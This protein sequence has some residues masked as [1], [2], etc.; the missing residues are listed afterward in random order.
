MDLNEYQKK[1]EASELKKTLNNQI[2]E[3]LELFV[4]LSDLEHLSFY[5]FD[6]EYNV[7]DYEYSLNKDGD[8]I[9]KPEHSGKTYRIKI[10]KDKLIYGYILIDRR[11]KS[12]KILK[13]LLDK[14][15][16]HFHEKKQLEK[17]LL[18]NDTSFNI[19]LVYDEELKAFSDN[20]KS[21]L[22]ALF[23]TEVVST[24]DITLYSSQ[25]KG[26]DTKH[27]IIYLVEDQNK[28]VQDEQII[29]GLN[30]LI[31]VIGPNDHSISMYCGKLG[32]ENYI[33]IN[34]FKA[35]N[36][37]SIILDTRKELLTKNKYGNKIIGITGITGG[38]GST[39]ISMNAC[40]LLSTNLPE[41]NILYIDLSNT[42]A[43][44]NLFLEGN[45]LPEKTIVDLINSSEFNIESN[46]ENGLIKRKEN[47][48][49]ITGIQKHIDKE[50][51]ERDVFIEKLLEYIS[52][53]SDYFNFIVI[54]LGEADASNLKS[55]LYDVVNEL[56]VITE[57]SLPHTSKLKT[58]YSLLK[59]AGLK[60]KTSFVIN[61]FDSKNAISISDATSILN[62]NDDEKKLF[63]E[64][65]IPN[66]YEDL[67][68]CWNY[69]KLASEHAK[70]SI[71]VKKLDSILENKGF[72][73]KEKKSETKSSLFSFFKK[74]K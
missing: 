28:I 22:K 35:E 19:F 23:N 66:D 4:D 46:L 29:K 52:S 72:Y 12:K 63:N 73:K 45:P 16:K 59:R 6:Y 42:K 57:M 60:D 58:F 32:I 43:I 5:K 50:Y 36:I 26:K 67:G 69:C 15:R 18:D 44:S 56:W 49:C 65:K 74:S 55:T 34:E 9:D 47:F 64:M 30:E 8:K 62:M 20:L 14:I 7:F 71:F 2:L 68:S 24:K 13:R 51:I 25:L 11:V 38:I 48:Y 3:L 17:T 61:R 33:S 27:I 54:D 1:M 21:G 70:N 39:T 10:K 40:D 53:S 31:I 37:K 41:K